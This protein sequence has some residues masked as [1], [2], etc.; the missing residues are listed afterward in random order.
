[1]FENALK[2]LPVGSEV[3]LLGNGEPLLNKNIYEMIRYAADSGFVVKMITNGTML[4]PKNIERLVRSGVDYLQISF[5]FNENTFSLKPDQKLNG[6]LDV[7][8]KIIE[9]IYTTRIVLKSRLF[10][11]I[12]TVLSNEIKKNISHARKF[13]NS[14][15]VNNFYEG[16][17][18]SLQTNSNALNEIQ[19]NSKEVYKVCANPFSAL[20]ISATGEVAGCVMDFSDKYII[21]NVADSNISE[22]INSEKAVLLRKAVFECDAKFFESCGYNCDKC[23]AW[24]DQ[25]GHNLSGYLNDGFPVTYGLLIE[26]ISNKEWFDNEKINNIERLRKEFSIETIKKYFI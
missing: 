26:A 2:G 18:L 6:S 17:L 4:T 23:N 25:V 8:K 1:M 9:F 3:N 16:E 19:N 13:W 20:K 24:T 15:P 21:G 22:I 5:D 7:L 14:L 10:I 12:S 11:S